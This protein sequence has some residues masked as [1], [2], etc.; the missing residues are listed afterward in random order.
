MDNLSLINAEQQAQGQASK[1]ETLR[2]YSRDPAAPGWR[3]PPAPGREPGMHYFESPYD[4]ALQFKCKSEK[5]PSVRR[6]RSEK[7]RSLEREAEAEATAAFAVQ[8]DAERAEARRQKVR[9]EAK[10]ALKAERK[11]TQA[12]ANAEAQLLKSIAAGA[13]A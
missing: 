5:W 1:D 13:R 7:L 11:A 12:R 8:M 3:L 10:I 4:S 2:P 6:A 9:T